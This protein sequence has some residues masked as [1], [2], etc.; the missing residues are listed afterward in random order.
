MAEPHSRQSLILATFERHDKLDQILSDMSD[1]E[2]NGTFPFKGRDRNV[3]DVLVQLAAW[4]KMYLDWSKANLAGTAKRFMPKPYSWKNSGKLSRK[5]WQAN[6]KTTLTEAKKA[7]ES[8]YSDLM[9]Q[10]EQANNEEMFL[11][12][13]YPWTGSLSLGEFATMVASTHYAWAIKVL[14]QYLK[15]TRAEK[16]LAKTK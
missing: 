7:F 16:P 6:Q 5:I 1:E 3:R 13:F 12:G 9:D 11:R 10:F 15:T 8:L 2:L 4:Q 14:T